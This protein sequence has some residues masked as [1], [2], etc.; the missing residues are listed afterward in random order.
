MSTDEWESGTIVL[1]AAEFAAFRQAVQA[2]DDAH[3]RRVFDQTQAFW[4]GLTRKQQTDLAAHKDAIYDWAAARHKADRERPLRRWPTAEQVRADEEDRR[5]F[6]DAYELLNNRL[7]YGPAAGKPSRVL[8]SEMKYP[9][10]RTT[11]FH[12][13]EASVTFD[14]AK[15]T[16]RWYVHRQNHAVERGRNTW[17]AQLFFE[18]LG[19]VRWTHGTG[20]VIT[21]NNDYNVHEHTGPGEGGNFVTGAYGYLGIEQAPN[22]VKPFTN[23]KGERIGAQAKRTRYSHVVGTPVKLDRWG[24]PIR[25]APPTSPGTARAKTTAKSTA[26]SFAPHHKA[27][28]DPSILG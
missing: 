17:L 21:G 16:V 1:P 11:A 3:K 18:R 12:A 23:A 24:Q 10:N 2:A 28:A 15:R 25:T 9:T 5:A 26:G 13:E 6:D 7:W 27:E 4:K 20:G 22:H 8:Q 19:K 14:P